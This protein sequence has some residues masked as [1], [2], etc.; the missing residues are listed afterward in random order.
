MNICRLQTFNY[1]WDSFNLPSKKTINVDMGHIASGHMKGGS[2][3]S[4]LKD[5]FP[6]HWS[7]DQVEQAIRDAYDQAKRI[8]SQGDRVL[9]RGV[10]DGLKIEMWLNKATRTIETAYPIYDDLVEI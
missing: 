7:V 6:D 5:V 3:L 2:R 8:G 4:P 1:Q 10:G 9:L